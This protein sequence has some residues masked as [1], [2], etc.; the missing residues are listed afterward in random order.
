MPWWRHRRRWPTMCRCGPSSCRARAPRSAQDSTSPASRPW[1]A[2]R[3]G[4]TAA[5]RDRAPP[6]GPDHPPRPAGG[7]GLARACRAG[8]RR[9][10]RRGVRCRLPA[11]GGCRHPLRGPRCAHVGARD[12]VG[13]EPRH[14][15]H[16]AVARS[17]RLRHGQR[18]DLDGPGGTRRRGGPHRSGHPRRRGS[19]RRGHGAGSRDRLEES[20]RHPG[21]EATRQ[22][23]GDRGLRGSVRG[24]TQGDRAA[25]RFAQPGG[26][27]HAFFDKR[28]P[29]YTDPGS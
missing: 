13:A 22:R 2:T 17:G 26:V 8:H 21:R 20:R 16:R 4:Q 23:G 18:A 27:R 10:P 12:P 9:G 11:R 7:V 29:D 15:H 3:V 28:D 5:P 24:R 19:P 25:D 6:R 1:P 14:D